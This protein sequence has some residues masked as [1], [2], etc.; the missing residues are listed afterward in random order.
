MRR[1][2]IAFLAAALVGGVFAQSED[3][4]WT[5]PAEY[6]GQTLNVYNWATYIAEDTISNFEAACDVTVVYDTYASDD[7]DRKSVV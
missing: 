5:C 3:S 2:L 1:I 7:E 6:A 4:E